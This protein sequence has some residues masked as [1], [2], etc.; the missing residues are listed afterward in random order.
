MAICPAAAG[1]HTMQGRH[2]ATG[3]AGQQPRRCGESPTQM[4]TSSNGQPR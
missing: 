2:P 4:S 3:C 1:L